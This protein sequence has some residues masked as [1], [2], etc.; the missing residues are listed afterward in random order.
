ML[1]GRHFADLP[2]PAPLERWRHVYNHERPHEALGQ[3]PPA[4]LYVPSPRP[5]P[6]RLPELTYAAGADVRRVRPNGALRWGIHEIYLS[7]ALAGELIGLEEILE[8]RWCV[9]FGPVTLGWLDTRAATPLTGRPRR[10]AVN[11]HL[12]PMC[13]V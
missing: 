1:N 7:Q 11:P 8:D 10:A 5:Y 4:R 3:R 12:L 9:R 6:E 2:M 13:P